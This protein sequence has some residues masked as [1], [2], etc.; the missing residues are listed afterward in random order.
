MIHFS[1]LHIGLALKWKLFLLGS[2]NQNKI[3]CYSENQKTMVQKYNIAVYLMSL[4]I[5]KSITYQITYSVVWVCL[6][7][8]CRLPMA[9]FSG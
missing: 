3:F 8:R 1:F 9:E 5:K 2:F 7:L 4:H 6:S